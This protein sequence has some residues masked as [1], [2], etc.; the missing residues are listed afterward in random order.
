MR[1]KPISFV[2]IVSSKI[3]M[4]QARLVVLLLALVFSVSASPKGKK[5]YGKKDGGGGG[6]GAVLPIVG[7]AAGVAGAVGLAGVALHHFGKKD[8]DKYG[9]P[10][11]GAPPSTPPPG[12]T[13]PPP[14]TTYPP[15][16]T[17]PTHNYGHG[18]RYGYGGK[19]D[20]STNGV[21]TPAAAP[22]TAP[23]PQPAPANEAASPEGDALPAVPGAPQDGDVLGVSTDG[24]DTEAPANGDGKRINSYEASSAV[25]IVSSMAL[26]VSSLFYLLI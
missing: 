21:T 24:E 4:V 16:G 2:S 15:P 22:P 17:N 7:I 5:S 12:P 26:A 19:H 8:Y 25:S 3:L 10:P 20:K 1:L 6:L 11:P 9:S 23:E 13:P 14:V 18:G